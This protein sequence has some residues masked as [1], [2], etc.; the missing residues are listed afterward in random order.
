MKATA[1]QISYINSLSKR[2]GK[3][4]SNGEST[5]KHIQW[6][7]DNAAEMTTKEASEWIDHL[8]ALIRTAN[9]VT[10]R[11]ATNGRGYQI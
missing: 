1:K 3:C 8:R 4:K 5:R 9:E 6:G 2:L 11:Y 10:A 7:V